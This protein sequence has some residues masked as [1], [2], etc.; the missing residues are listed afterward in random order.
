MIR[1]LGVL[2]LFF[3]GIGTAETALR[4]RRRELDTMGEL[5]YALHR[6]ESAVRCER[7]P[8]YPLFAS[9]AEELRGEGGRFFR[10]LLERERQEPESALAVD[11][12]R[13]T[14]MLTLPPEGLRIWRELGQRL[15]GDADSV[16]RA[17]ALTAEELTAL[18]QGMEH[19]LPQQRRVMTALSL[20]G[21]A[22]LTV[23]LL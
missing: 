21:A 16:E 17:L 3:S 9:L 12:V 5:L 22:F 6:L 2:L 14:E 10:A 20:S 18:R 8:L 13:C 11:W 19:A 7:R 23:L 15:S 1:V 4:R